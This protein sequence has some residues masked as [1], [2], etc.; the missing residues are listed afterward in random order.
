MLK[1]ISVQNVDCFDFHLQ[2]V[3]NVSKSFSKNWRK[4]GGLANLR[5]DC[6]QE[7]AEIYMHNIKKT[8]TT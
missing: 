7:D 6:K 1:G 2:N 8:T 3:A 5:T 4:E